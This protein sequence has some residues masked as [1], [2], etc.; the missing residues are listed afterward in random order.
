VTGLVDDLLPARA[1][2]AQAKARVLRE[3]LPW[4]TRW[5]GRTVVVKYGG[6]VADGGGTFASDVALLHRVGLRVVVVH[7]GG[8]QISRLSGRLGIEPRFVQGRRVTDPA[9]LDVVQMVLLGQVNP[10]LVG[11]ISAAGATAVGVS[12]TDGTLLTVAP[13]DA[14]LGR[15]GDVAAVN[16]H[17]LS[18]LL[19]EGAV[20][21]VAPLGRGPDGLPY[22]VNADAA[23]GALAAALHADKLLV[24]TNVAGLYDDFGAEGGGTLLATTTPAHL[25]ELLAAGALSD[26]MVPKI[27]SVLTAL[28]AGVA[29]AHLLDGRAEHALLLEIFT[30]EGVGTMI[31]RGTP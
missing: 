10:Q 11:A 12:G 16:P 7:G 25:R 29:S 15:V 8:P 21:V 24:L 30:D 18:T 13:A 28:D 19:D 9:T 20:P 22:N 3:A 1:R 31:E 17:V 23:A 5:A 2:D 27:A 26:G 14:A 6:S 4:I